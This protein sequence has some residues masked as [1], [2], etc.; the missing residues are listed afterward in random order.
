V[1]INHTRVTAT[2]FPSTLWL[3]SADEEDEVQSTTALI[4]FIEAART[5]MVAIYKG[6][7]VV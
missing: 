5:T 4:G 1:L 3:Y 6:L 2:V 7:R